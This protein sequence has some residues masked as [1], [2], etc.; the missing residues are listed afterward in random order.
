VPAALA[1]PHPVDA[2]AQPLPRTAPH[3]RAD[4]PPRVTPVSLRCRSQLAQLLEYPLD[5]GGPPR[6]QHAQ[7]GL[8]ALL[9]MLRAR[10]PADLLAATTKLQNVI[11]CSPAAPTPPVETV[12]AVANGAQPGSSGALVSGLT[13]NAEALAKALAEGTTPAH[14]T[15]APRPTA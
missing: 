2:H 8:D 9:G 10:N 6:T 15:R 14:D 11:G 12:I 5:E 3:H 7:D 1:L 4:S 13:P